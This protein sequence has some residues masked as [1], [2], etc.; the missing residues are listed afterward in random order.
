M[1]KKM[2]WKTA[3]KKAMK[4]AAKH[5]ALSRYGS[6]KPAFNYRWAHVQA[7]VD[8][9]RK[10]AKKTGADKDV[11]EAA[12]WLH[13]VRKEANDRHS[14]AGAKFARE[15]LKK[16]D[17]PK[18]KIDLVCQAIEDHMGLWRKEPLTLLESQVLW[19]ADKLTKLGY[20]AMF[21]RL[22]DEWSRGNSLDLFD[23][24]KDGRSQKKWM[25][26][27]VDSMHTK[28]ARKAA[29]KR[30]ATLQKLWDDLSDELTAADL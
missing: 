30:Y 27:T 5:Q 2:K 21:H 13:D 4:Q 16:T 11:V 25:Q 8:V 14:V 26:K 22:G 24:I 12:A 3:V 7:V 23:L 1:A 15:L 6:K 10:L 28:Q 19:D 17:F 20:T 18:D 9:A 29:K